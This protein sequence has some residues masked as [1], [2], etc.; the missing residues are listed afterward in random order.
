MNE[1]KTKKTPGAK[2]TT[3]ETPSFSVGD[4]AFYPG[5]GIVRIVSC[6]KHV[7]G[8]QEHEMYSLELHRGGKVMLPTS[9]IR[10]LGVRNIISAAE[11][12]RIVEEYKTGPKLEPISDWRTRANEH[13]EWLASGTTEGYTRVLFE[14]LGTKKER[15]ALYQRHPLAH[16]GPRLLSLRACPRA[17]IHGRG[18]STVAGPRCRN[19]RL[20]DEAS[21]G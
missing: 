10:E 3:P 19:H 21:Y 18:T 6:D 12:K 16:R 4:I 17:R 11:A 7:V 9:R 13:K 14:L 1:R 15:K 2:K 5:H 20:K 8:D